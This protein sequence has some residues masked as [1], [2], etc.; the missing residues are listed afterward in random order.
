MLAMSAS[1]LAAGPVPEGGTPLVEAADFARDGAFYGGGSD[2]Q[3]VAERAFVAVEGEPF[4][5][6]TRITVHHPE[7]KFWTAAMYAHAREAVQAGDAVLVRCRMRAVK[8]TDETGTVSCQVYAQGPGPHYRKSLSVE[9]RAGS[10]WQEFFL[11]FALLEAYPKG[12]L[13]FHFGF[14]GSNR[15]QV[16]ELA[17]IEIR[18]YGTRLSLADLPRT[19]FE[20]DGQASDAPW[21]AAAAARIAQHRKGDFAVTVRDAAGQPVTGATVRVRMR[22]HAY[23]FGSVVTA[24][25]IMDQDS[26]DARIY[27]EKVLELFNATGPENDL[28]WPPWE[29]DWGGHF[30]RA[31]TLAA[32]TWLK[33]QGLYLRG[34]VLVWPH[35]RN[36]PKRL[37][38]LIAARDPG[39]PQ[40][41]LDHIAEI[42]PATAHILDEWDVLNEP[43]DNHE[44][45]DIYGRAIMADWF[46]AARRHHP[47]AA[48]YI[49]DYAILSAGGRDLAHQ[50]HYE[51]TIRFLL[52]QGAPL[53]GIGMQGHFDANPT[54]IPKV[55]QI[56]DHFA[57]AFPAQAIKVTEFDV[58]TDDE[59]LQADYTRDFMTALFSHPRT[60]GFQ[61]WGFWEGA[62]WRPRAAMFGRDWREKPMARAYRD[63]VLKDWWTD[64]SGT[65]GPDGAFAGRGFIGD[66]EASVDGADPVPFTIAPG[67]NHAEIRLP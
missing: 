42:V 64:L 32:F 1:A 22:R 30:N 36:L 27:R 44:L 59:Q 35:S 28:K 57:A 63:L 62:H 18:H 40:L 34:H 4:A 33:E 60:V 58:D 5:Q 19:R 10:A 26:A 67:Q 25:R 24:A 56:L 2:G 20:Y 41:V 49:N 17:D 6:A 43:Y 50:R 55:L 53:D 12:E 3:P 8:T 38:P 29:A 48:L 11:P 7:G 13:S 54:G 45:M 31:Q 61:M 66:H 9:I 15:P 37:Q 16:L 65:T 39:V 47:T 14:G 52:D 23:K 51:E 46:R 21:R